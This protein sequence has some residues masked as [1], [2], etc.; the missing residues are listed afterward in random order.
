MEEEKTEASIQVDRH[1][2]FIKFPL[3]EALR[4]DRIGCWFLK[5]KRARKT[6]ELSEGSHPVGYQLKRSRTAHYL[7]FTKSLYHTN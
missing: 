1:F 3:E 7:I 5:S 2:W 4:C 6:V